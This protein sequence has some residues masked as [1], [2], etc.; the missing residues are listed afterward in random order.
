MS[1]MGAGAIGIGILLFG[2]WGGIVP[3]AGPAFGFSGDGAVS[4]HWNLAHAMMWLVPGALACVEGLTLLGLLP[5]SFTRVA[6]VG[7][8]TSGMI[9]IACGAWFVIGPLA[10]RVLEHT[11]VFITAAPLRE[12]AYQVGYSLGPGLLLVM[13]GAFAMAAAARPGRLVSREETMDSG[14]QQMLHHAA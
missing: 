7:S 5:R 2:A 1:W 9:V 12:L 6:R 8:I 13:L 11:R 10:W 3:Y 4:W 14:G